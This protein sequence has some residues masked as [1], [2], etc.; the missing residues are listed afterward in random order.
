MKRKMK[1]NVLVLVL[2]NSVVR[3]KHYLQA[4]KAVLL[5][6]GGLPGEQRAVPACG[7]AGRC[8]GDSAA[9]AMLFAGGALCTMLSFFLSCCQVQC[10]LRK[11]TDGSVGPGSGCVLALLSRYRGARHCVCSHGV[12]V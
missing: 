6:W 3:S 12:G 11:E 2:K 7:W 9:K 5:T 4:L 10:G 8:A 1:K